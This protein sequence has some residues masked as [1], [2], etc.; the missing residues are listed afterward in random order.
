MEIIKINLGHYVKKYGPGCW[1][2]LYLLCQYWSA[3]TQRCANCLF[4]PTSFLFSYLLQYPQTGISY[5][6]ERSHINTIVCILYMLYIEITLLLNRLLKNPIILKMMPYIEINNDISLFIIINIM[7]LL[8]SWQ[9][10]SWTKKL[11]LVMK[12]H[13]QSN[14]TFLSC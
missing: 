11:W 1:N 12:H 13:N 9:Y 5:S 6:H 2:S 3:A 4:S 14:T 7:Q 10:G 8:V